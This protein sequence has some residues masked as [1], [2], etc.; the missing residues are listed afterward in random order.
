MDK[1]RWLQISELF[2]T[3]TDISDESLRASY[4]DELCGEDDELRQALDDLLLAYAETGDFLEAPPHLEAQSAMTEQLNI[5]LLGQ[6]LGAW[7]I[8]SLIHYGGMGAVFR[9]HR[10]DGEY[11]QIA[12]IKVVQAGHLDNPDMLEKFTQERSLLAR[13]EHHNIARLLDGGT[14]DDGLSFLVMEY[15]RGIPIDQWCENQRL[16]ISEIID[17]FL[18]VCA[19]VQ[20]AHRFLIVHQDI[21][22][23]NILVNTEGLPKLLDFGIARILGEELD[24]RSGNHLPHGITPG[25]SSPEQIRGENITI[26]SDVYSLGALLH[27]LMTTSPHSAQSELMAIIGKAMHPLAEQRYW[28]VDALI[29]DLQR[30]IQHWPVKAVGDSLAYRSKKFFQRNWR[31]LSVSAAIAVITAVGLGTSYWQANIAE[32][33]FDQLHT[34]TESLLFDVHDSVADLP[35]STETRELIA[36]QALSYLDGLSANSKNEPEVLFS[37]AQG[38]L[39]LGRVLGSPTNANLG[40]SQGALKHYQHS[41]RIIDQLLRQAPSNPEYLRTKALALQNISEIEANLNDVNQAVDRLKDATQILAALHSL[42]PGN[43]IYHMDYVINLVKLGDITGNRTFVNTG[44][45]EQAKNY[46]QQALNTLSVDSQENNRDW[47]FERYQALILERL[48]AIETDQKN[49]QLAQGYYQKSKAARLK[50]AEQHP[51]KIEIQRDAGVAHGK[52]GDIYVLLSEPDKALSEYLSAM[53][54]YQGLVDIDPSN[55]SAQLTLAIGM[56]YVGDGYRLTANPDKAVDFYNQSLNLHHQLAE[57]DPNN[58]LFLQKR[59]RAQHKL[60]NLIHFNND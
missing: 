38:Y 11:D 43:R 57:R 12:A 19:A 3:A 25:Y 32:Q 10:A 6:Q 44:E 53:K 27:K 23:N 50:L 30:F 20:Y 51:D 35:G 7:E 36:A 24:G 56:E 49:V 9:A 31:S 52:M 29:N 59:S 2:N 16:N 41:L 8:D 21:K 14:T 45:S 13:L 33:R 58:Q 54:I 42:Y 18:Q 60:D 15:V 17:L 40:D 48:G 55:V 5:Q 28:S 34:L 26:A 46:Y 1:A 22:P 39:R 4:L 47:R 37:L